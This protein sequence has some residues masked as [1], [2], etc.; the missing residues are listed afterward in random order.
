MYKVEF[1]FS[2][3][4]VMMEASADNVSVNTFKNAVRLGVSK[5]QTII[6]K[7]EA[8]QKKHGKEKRKIEE[9]PSLSN[10]LLTAVSR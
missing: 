1:F 8:L 4:T 9:P 7:I 3:I 5:V 2:K 10:K 6:A